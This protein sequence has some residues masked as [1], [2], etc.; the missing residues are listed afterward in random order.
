MLQ[1]LLKRPDT[2]CM[3]GPRAEPVWVVQGSGKRTAARNGLASG[4]PVVRRPRPI[5]VRKG[6]RCPRPHWVEQW[7]RLGPAN[8][9][10]GEAALERNRA[11]RLDS[12]T[13]ALTPVLASCPDRPQR[14]PR[15]WG[16]SESRQDFFEPRVHTPSGPGH[17]SVELFRQRSLKQHLLTRKR[18]P[19]ASG[20]IATKPIPDISI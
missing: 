17:V 2:L 14:F 6:R 13:L 18:P 20:H 3:P 5:A 1:V 15:R 10:P 19:C 12:M 16:R 11:A 8:R 7:A 9:V 4:V